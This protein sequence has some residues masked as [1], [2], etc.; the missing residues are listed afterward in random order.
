TTYTNTTAH[1]PF[2]VT[3]GH[4]PS[5]TPEGRRIGVRPTGAY[6]GAGSE[7]IDV[8]SGNL[9]FTL[10]LLSAQSR[11][12]WSAGFALNYNSQNWRYDPSLSIPNW[13]YG[14]DVGYGYGWRLMAGSITP[15]FSDPNTLSY[16]L[17]TDST[18]AQYRLDQ[19]NGNV[20]S[21]KESAYVFF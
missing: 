17:F 10:P 8:L 3:D 20:W 15:V 1:T 6:W 12:G 4:W 9:N 5:S 14:A 7:N 13:N 2:I 19:P 18:G 11:S 21:S 16:Y